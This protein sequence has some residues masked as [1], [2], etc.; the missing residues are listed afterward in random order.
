LTCGLLLI[1]VLACGASAALLAGP[2]ILDA[3]RDAWG[4]WQLSNRQADL[5]AVPGSDRTPMLFTVESGET[6]YTVALK[7]AA[8]SFIDDPELLYDYVRYEGFDTR[9]GAGT[10]ALNRSLSI[11]QIVARL[12]DPA[13]RTVTV[14]MLDGWRIEELVA[15]LDASPRLAFSGQDFAALVQAGAPVDPA[16][17]ALVGLP[18]GA[19]L[20]GF[21][22]PGSYQVPPDTGPDYLLNAMLAA[23]TRTVSENGITAAAAADGLSLFQV[24]TLASIVRREAVQ[25]DEMPL[26]AGVYLNRLAINMKLDADPTV[27]YGLGNSRGDWWPRITQADYTGV[28]SPYNTYR[29]NG[30]PPGPIASAGRAALL[31]VVNPEPSTFYFFRADCRSDGYHDFAE[32]YEDHLANGC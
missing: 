1:A 27:Q 15:S 26:I 13:A 2:Q 31:A 3:V 7:L 20:E 24:A 29:V 10:Y 22:L 16:F 14:N 19:S 25:D 6:P 17:A 28:Q 9:I 32:T 18:A 11:R 21:L 8:A 5:D 4:R 12:T 23:F 30:L